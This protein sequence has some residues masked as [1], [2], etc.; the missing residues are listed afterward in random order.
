M[1]K[2]TDNVRDDQISNE[3]AAGEIVRSIN[4]IGLPTPSIESIT[5]SSDHPIPTGTVN[6]S[7]RQYVFDSTNLDKA[8][9]IVPSYRVR[10][11]A[12]LLITNYALWASHPSTQTIT[13]LNLPN[14]ELLWQTNVH[15]E[16]VTVSRVSPRLL[17]TCFDT[18]EVIVIQENTG[19]ILNRTF[20]GNGPFGILVVGDGVFVTLNGESSLLK[21]ELDSLAQISRAETG[22]SPS[23][24]AIKDRSL[25]VVHRSDDDVMVFDIHSLDQV[26]SIELGGQSV[27]GESITLHESHPRAYVPHQR[28]NVANMARLF[29]TTV[30]PVVGVLD[31]DDLVRKVR[32]TL[33]LDSIDTPV[34]MPTAAVLG[35]QGDRLYVVNAASDDV[36]VVSLS[37]QPSIGHIVVGQNPRDLAISSSGELA[38]TLNLVSDDISVIDTNTL[39][40]VNTFPLVVDTRPILIQEGERL[41]FTSRP[42]EIAKDNWM[43]CASCHFDGGTDGQTWLGTVGG[44]RNT[45]ILR[46]IAS[47]EPLHWSADRADLLTFQQTFTGLMA[48]TGLSE[49]KLEALAQ[50][51]NTLQPH[52][53]PLRLNG[54]DLSVEARRGGQIF[55]SAGCLVCH[56]PP[57]FTDQERHDVGTG[58][59]FYDHPDE[60][61]KILEV[62]GVA[63]D[64]PSLRE[65]WS[66]PPFLHDG[67]ASTLREVLVK[68]NPSENHGNTAT[69]SE[70]ELVALE[71]FLLSLPL[72]ENE[73]QEIFD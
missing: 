53:S 27:M 2:R 52:S 38:Y 13:Q 10:R 17:A 12:R 73:V 28:Q 66:T 70:F 39:E 29:D 68:F 31:T 57:L 56:F 49:Q 33:A 48:G 7:T 32:E 47:T 11:T 22:L 20:V 62:M 54:K 26:G 69:L 61:G 40:V 24:M 21:L 36:S 3:V 5:H 19:K 72:S 15:C 42:D 63:F 65:L 34:G 45:P 23:G 44:P 6:S 58:T 14:G 51:I 35:P 64:T 18:G 46:G 67:R 4:T 8:N 30:S 50:Y 25:F 41:F 59:E 9:L 71:T 43:S 37:Q 60:S 1:S 16:P 55:K